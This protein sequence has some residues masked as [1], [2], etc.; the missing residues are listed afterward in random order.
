MIRWY[1]QRS[2]VDGIVDTLE[3]MTELVHA[4][5]THPLI[6]EQAVSAIRS[7]ERGNLYCQMASLMVWV[8]RSMLFVKDPVGVEA[9]HEPLAIAHAIQ[10]GRR[11]YGDCDD[12]SIYLATL[13]QSVGIPATFRA[14]GFAG[15][16]IS[17]V[18]VTG[19]RGIRLDPTRNIWNPSLGETLKETTMIERR[20]G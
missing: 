11:P 12:F 2:G 5:Y 4:A 7:C 1:P 6:R 14:V 3:R 8:Q 19:P 13:M 10:A 9:L 20:V 18:Y 17:H 15:R 16:P